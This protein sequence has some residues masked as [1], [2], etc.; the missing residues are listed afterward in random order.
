MATSR[1]DTSVVARVTIHS[2]ASG[3]WSQ[4]TKWMLDAFADSSTEK[5]YV[6]DLWAE[7]CISRG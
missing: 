7:S 2:K 3:W 4:G 5:Q 1:T 6:Q